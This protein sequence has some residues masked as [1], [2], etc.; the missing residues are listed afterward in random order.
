MKRES[1]ILMPISSL[2]SPYGVGDFGKSAF[3]FI[4]LLKKGG[5]RLWQILPL[6]P[7]GYGHSP[8]QA[9]SSFA[10]DEIYIDLLDLHKRGLLRKKPKSFNENAL[11]VDYEAV[12]SYKMPFVYEAYRNAKKIEKRETRDFRKSHQWVEAWSL[13]MMNLRRNS[14]RSWNEWPK[15]HQE[16]FPGAKLTLKEKD[17]ANFEIWLQ[18]TL[19]R[20]WKAIKEKANASNIRIIGDIPFYVGYNS[21][22]VW[23]NQKMF[24]LDP[25]TKEPSWIAGVPPDYFSATG[26]RWG[27]PIYDWDTLEKDNFRFILNR[28]EGNA[29]LYDVIRLDHFRA[30]D[31]YWKIPSSCP[32]AEEGAWIEAPGYKVFCAFYA[33]HLPVE[34]IAEDL[35][36]L[37]PEVL[38]LRD[39][40]GFP[41]MNV[42]EFSFAAMEIDGEEDIDAENMV[43]Y[44][45]THDNDTC[46]GFYDSLSPEDQAKWS[47]A[48][49]SAGYDEKRFNE[50]MIRYLLGLKAKYAIISLQ[51][52]LGLGNEARINVPG[53]VNDINWTWHLASFDEFGLN[54]PLLRR[55][56][57]LARRLA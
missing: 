51:D 37:R 2:P 43:A 34:I 45:G 10:I 6:N 35:G 29:E 50:A 39:L 22:D 9:F 30:F 40:C 31:T 36:D 27:N 13:F 28:L 33:R 47:E 23:N 18:M 49:L 32:T 25:E 26:Q 53:I 52:V 4:A 8:Y 24:L 54:L 11:K 38:R 56:N 46:I 3:E 15:E 5:F 21:C 19:Y 44:I 42:V 48:L 7:L 55:W 1:G 14:L 57:K 16:M 12:R 17:A 41:G 20:Q